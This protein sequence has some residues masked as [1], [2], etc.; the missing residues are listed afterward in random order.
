MSRIRSIL[1]FGI[2]AVAALSMTAV[3]VAAPKAKPKPKPKPAPKTPAKTPAKP[4]P[5]KTTGLEYQKSINIGGKT[6]T[7]SGAKYESA[8][9]YTRGKFGYIGGK[10]RVAGKV[11]DK[12]LRSTIDK[13]KAVKFTV[14]NGKYQIVLI[15]GEFWQTKPGV[16]VFSVRIE[17]KTV[18][19]AVDLARAPGH[20]RRYPYKVKTNVTDGLL[21]IML[22]KKGRLYPVLCAVTVKRIGDLPGQAATMAQRGASGQGRPANYDE[23][24]ELREK[25]A[26]VALDAANKILGKQ[27]RTDDDL[28]A[29]YEAL[30]S[31]QKRYKQT[32]TGDLAGEKADELLG[33][34]KLGRTIR[35]IIK[36]RDAAERLKLA[37]AYI[38][39]KKY[40]VAYQEL[41]KIIR[42][43]RTT[44]SAPEALKLLEQVRKIRAEARRKK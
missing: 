42:E 30:R 44:D 31:I 1:G 19:P 7:S 17:G 41:R 12:V 21:D 15:F 39:I 6:S 2:V 14:P 24:Q 25:E 34:I 13:L 10:P 18:L 38:Q 4:A 5:P 43:Y 36:N 29:G 33:D 40:E 23:L 22:L 9:K 20:S 3:C 27:K 32:P 11:R 35:K 28:V 16:R 37:R 26:K 8:P